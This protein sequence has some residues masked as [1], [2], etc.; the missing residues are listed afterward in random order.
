MK[1]QILS[2]AGMSLTSSSGSQVVCDPWLIG[3]TYWRSWF[4]YPPVEEDLIA[5]LKP[6]AIYLTHVH[7]DHFAGPSLRLFDP[8]IP[9]IIPKEPAG[10]M[11]R[12][13]R[14]D[15]KLN[16]IVELSHGESFMV[17]DIK[18]TSYQFF[19]FVDSAVVL[20][21]DDQVVFN[22]NDAKF[23]GGPLKQILNNHPRMDFVL[24]S[25]SSANSRICYEVTD[26]PLVE[27]DDRD[28]YIKNFAEFVQA[29]GATH[30][31]PFAS[32]HCHLHKEVLDYNNYAVSQQEVADYFVKHNITDPELHVM[33]SG[34]YYD[35]EEGFVIPENDWFT[36]RDEHIVEYL[37]RE[38]DRLEKTY[39]LEARAKVNMKRTQKY[40]DKIFKAMPWFI[41]RLY[42]EDPVLFVLNSDDKQYLIEADFY[43]KTVKEID[44]YTDESHPFQIIVATALFNHCMAVDLFSHLAISKRVRYRMPKRLWKRARVLAYFFNFYEYEMLP[45]RVL[46]PGRFIGQWALRWRE[47]LLYAR[48]GLDALFGKS[49]DYRRYLEM[50]KPENTPKAEAKA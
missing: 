28:Q 29:T 33:I 26:D 31:I 3:S 9:I 12:D 37:E 42:R 23:M 16:N 30:A 38:K 24:R 11:A 47:V 25:H 21:C 14:K 10:R 7:W 5:S 1:L 32:N 41:R 40:F 20:E 34:D 17:G 8:D 27:V 43:N 19:V 48:I 18:L 4:N 46:K 22:A 13:L 36:R 6:D 35:T 45:L 2:H 49:F 39:A 50:P 15:M 44:S